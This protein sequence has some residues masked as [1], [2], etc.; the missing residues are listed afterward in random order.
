MTVPILYCVEP[1][2]GIARARNRALSNAVGDYFA[3][4]DDDEIPIHEWL[5]WLFTQCNRFGVDGVLGPVRNHYD[6]QPPRWLLQ[7]GLCD[8]KIQPTGTP[9]C[10]LEAR[11]GN[12]LLRA[13]VVENDKEPF[14]VE[15]TAGEDQDFFRRKIASGSSFIWSAEAVAYEVVPPA[16]WERSYYLKRAFLNGEMS[17][18]MSPASVK[19]AGKSLLAVLL[20]LVM[21]PLIL[22]WGQHRM[23]D[24]LIRL[25]FH[26]GRLFAMVNLRSS[27]SDLCVI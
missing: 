3:L 21:L 1:Q 10:W 17:L 2:Q 24:M 13:A 19:S 11:T 22:P 16:R 8:R 5:L 27:L 23:M 15:F 18:M 20:Y 4:I 9:V 6:Q 26:I 25:G 12:V 7:C 14:R